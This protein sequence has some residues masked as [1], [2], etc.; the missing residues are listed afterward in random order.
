MSRVFFDAILE[1]NRP[2][3]PKA[4]AILIGSVALFSFIAGIVFILH[5][6]WPVTPFLGGDV[7]LLAWAMRASV[8]AARRRE[9]LILTQDSLLIERVAANGCARREEVNPY[10][11]RVEHEDPELLGCELALVSRG[12]RLVVGSFLGAEERANL[13][14]ALRKALREAHDYMPPPA[15]A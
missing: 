12:H 8:K 2:L 5:G 14:D 3:S 9:H 4:L 10:W 13:A 7:A 15:G 6:A 11:L 1:P